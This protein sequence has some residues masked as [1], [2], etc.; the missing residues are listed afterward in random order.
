M[1]HNNR[2]VYSETAYTT[3]S[4]NQTFFEILLVLLLL[5]LC[6]YKNMRL[7]HIYMQYTHWYP[8]LTHIHI[9]NKNNTNTDRHAHKYRHM[10]MHSNHHHISDIRYS[11]VRMNY[12]QKLIWMER[13]DEILN[14]M[15]SANYLNRF[16][17][18][19]KSS[20]LLTFFFRFGWELKF[21]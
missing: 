7:W 11:V 8:P 6:I 5:D 12:K 4:P 18:L 13:S 15:H 3:Q 9:H 19:V 2:N 14:E 10:H 1:Q 20:F 16:D 21:I 17:W